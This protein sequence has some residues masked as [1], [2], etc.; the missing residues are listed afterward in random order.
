MEPPV[1]RSN[2]PPNRV[3]SI[4]R[5]VFWAF[6][7]VVVALLSGAGLVLLLSSIDA[8]IGPAEP[9]HPHAGQ[10]VP[11]RWGGPGGI[12]SSPYPIRMALYEYS[13]GEDYTITGQSIAFLIPKYFS[14]ST[15]NHRGGP[16]SA[17]WL[18]INPRT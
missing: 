2:V 10:R 14:N 6:F 1:E 4:R 8:A 12:S 5:V 15:D 9:T 18:E 13:D 16:Q 3:R 17:L 11:A 7:A